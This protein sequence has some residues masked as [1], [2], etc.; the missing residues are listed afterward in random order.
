[1]PM[2]VNGALGDKPFK[3][4]NHGFQGVLDKK[5]IPTFNLNSP[6]ILELT[7]RLFCSRQAL[8]SHVSSTR[9]ALATCPRYQLSYI[10][11]ADSLF[12]LS[13]SLYPCSRQRSTI[14]ARLGVV[15][16]GGRDLPIRYLSIVAIIVLLTIR[17]PSL[18]HSLSRVLVTNRP[19]RPHLSLQAKDVPGVDILITACGEDHDLTMNVVR[20]ACETDWAKDRLH[21]ILLD[22]GRSEALQD[23]MQRLQRTYPWAHYTRRKKP[24]IPDYKAG[25]LNHGLLYSAGLPDGPFPFVAGLDVD[26]IVQPHWL[27]ALMPHLL[28]DPQ[29]AM[30]CARQVSF[31]QILMLVSC[32]DAYSVL[33]QHPQR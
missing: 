27:R 31:C 5:S 21:V 19:R 7:T 29:L 22:D 9:V 25:N 10:G 8:N 20:A 17:A 15:F 2:T 13:C 3:P 12:C 32:S 11:R 18:L 23:S 28:D 24:E 26:M 6:S 33:L 30:T 1:M 4:A 16:S 14:P